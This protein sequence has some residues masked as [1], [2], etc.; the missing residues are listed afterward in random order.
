MVITAANIGEVIRMDQ[1]SQCIL[2]ENVTDKFIHYCKETGDQYATSEREVPGSI[3]RDPK[4]IAGVCR[5]AKLG[6][7]LGSAELSA[8]RKILDGSLESGQRK[9]ANA[10]MGIVK[11]MQK[12]LE[13]RVAGRQAEQ[14]PARHSS[15][16]DMIR[17]A[18][19]DRQ[20]P[21]TRD[22]MRAHGTD[23]SAGR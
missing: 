22:N 16:E 8:F 5:N 10:V 23:L 4:V 15:L 11:G 2:I 14:N 13:E 9:E 20:G 7:A 6:A 1:K 18:N 12:H 3:V 21:G 17:K 19:S